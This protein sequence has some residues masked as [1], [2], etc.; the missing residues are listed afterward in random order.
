MSGRGAARRRLTKVGAGALLTLGSRGALAKAPTC[1]TPSG[2]WSSGL[3]PASSHYGHETCSGGRL[4]QHWLEC[5]TSWP[6]HI[7]AEKF[8]FTAA[9]PMAGRAAGCPAPSKNKD[10]WEN[11]WKNKDDNSRPAPTSYECAL[12]LDMLSQQGFDSQGLGMY[13]A[14]TYLN[15]QAGYVTF[16]TVAQLRAIWNDVSP[17]G[18]VF[19]PTA[20]V[21]W[22]RADVVK[23]LMATMT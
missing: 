10:S 15:I 20:G 4:P 8:L 9:F 2:F 23:Y 12:L 7:D 3:N 21:D 11:R 18:G 19:H 14:A 1:L 13:M 5:K 17:P 16:L 22:G 6:G